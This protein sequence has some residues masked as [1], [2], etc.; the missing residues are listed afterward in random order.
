MT[1]T[2]LAAGRRLPADD[3]RDI[4]AR[5][6][7]CWEEL[8]AGR[9]FITGGTGFIGRWLVESI[10]AASEALALKCEL[11]LLTRDPARFRR[12]APHVAEHPAIT[13]VEGDV[14]ALP[15]LPWTPEVVIHGAADP[16]A[17]D[18][19]GAARELFHTIVDGTAAV[20]AL[21]ERGSARHVLFLSSGAVY[22]S[23]P[24]PPGGFDEDFRGAP[25]PLDPRSAYGE[26]KRAAELL[27]ALHESAGAKIARCFAFIG[28]LLPLDGPYA[29]GNF[30]RDALAGRPL[31]ASG[32]GTAVRSYLYAA[33]LAAWLLRILVRGKCGR[34]YNVGS[35]HPVTI[36]E[37][38]EA[39]GA[40]TECAEPARFAEPG[41]GAHR[42][43]PSTRRAESELGVAA[44][45][46]LDAAI[47]KTLAWHRAAPAA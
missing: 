21:A 9:I 33:D 30:L 27:C 41:E 34:A 46:P 36:R 25:D 8:R 31:R 17:R 43:L 29:A 11:C 18:D 22:G 5:G 40:Q 14:K 1:S 32:D 19:R 7:D 38:A 4:V 35:P 24:S 13:L 6:G 26:G 12:A 3:L 39:I 44:W 45:T 20:L 42:Y 23:Q 16:L 28:P 15:P 47:R 2:F 37:L 10:L